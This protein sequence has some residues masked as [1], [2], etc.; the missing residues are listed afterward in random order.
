MQELKLHSFGQT[1]HLEILKKK[2]DSLKKSI[3]ENKKLT[4]SEKKA[5]L[6][7]LTKSFEKEKKNS[8]NNLY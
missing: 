4:E 3:N 2:Y 8:N 5:E 6:E 7:T 1:D